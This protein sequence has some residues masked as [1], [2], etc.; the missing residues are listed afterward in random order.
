MTLRLGIDVA[1]RSPHQVTCADGAGEFVFTGRRFRSTVEDLEKLWASLPTGEDI[2]VIMEP[3]R[4]A[5]VLLAAWFTAHDATVCLVPPEQSADLRDYYNK[6]TKTDRLD[7]RVLARLPLLHPE[8]LR[9][10]TDAGPADP[11]RRAVRRR[12][13]LVQR[14]TA[15]YSRIDALLELLSP[16]WADILGSDYTKT[17]L[18]VLQRT[19]ADPKQI[20]KLGRK[21]LTELLIRTSHGHWRETHADAIIAAA[22]ETTALWQ[23]GGLD[24][25]ELATDIAAE[26]RVAAQLSVEIEQLDQRIQTLY[27]AADPAQLVISTPGL[28]TT[29]AAGI[30]GRLGDPNRFANLAGVRAFTGLVPSI[31]QSGIAD[32]HGPPT[33]AGD[34]GLREALVNGADRAR[35][36]DPTLA[37]R[38]Q[39]LVVN[40]GKHHNA[41]LCTLGAMLATRIAACWRTGAYYELRDTDGT[42][43]TEQQGRDICATR[44]KVTNADRAKKRSTRTSQ[45]LKQRTS[46]RNKE[47]HSA[48]TT[49]PLKTDHTSP[50]TT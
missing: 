30:L 1:C 31:D 26:A 41:A 25:A 40:K 16:A 13:S 9:P 29:L 12:S 6:H 44:Y 2:M 32:R 8:G 37:C 43:I 21:R 47:S 15:A 28:R 50:A 5:W 24:F 36:V 10:V 20:T 11:L 17:A 3:T 19:G 38:Y 42:P 46:R 4:N 35:A 34:S 23:H 49:G 7:S 14:R 33:K 27:E 39:D 22:T 45:R 18:T 48:P